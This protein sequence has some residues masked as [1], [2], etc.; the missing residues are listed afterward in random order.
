MWIS[1][2]QTRRVGEDSPPISAIDSAHN[3]KVVKSFD[4]RPWNEIT[5]DNI[6]VPS[7]I[8]CLFSRTAPLGWLHM[9]ETWQGQARPSVRPA[10]LRASV[11]QIEYRQQQ[12]ED[13]ELE[14]SGPTVRLDGTSTVY[15]IAQFTQPT[16]SST[17]RLLRMTNRGKMMI[18]FELPHE[19][20]LHLAEAT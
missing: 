16:S 12:H 15:P 10:P 5:I 20:E 11:L 9:H 4:K 7:F 18:Y 2:N 19:K 3:R 13:T 17:F 8:L 14:V 6:N 1:V